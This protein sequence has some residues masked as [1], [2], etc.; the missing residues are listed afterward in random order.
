MV[1]V[2]VLVV[3]LSASAGDIDSVVQRSNSEKVRMNSFHFR[4]ESESCEDETPGRPLVLDSVKEFW[5]SGNSFRQRLRTFYAINSLGEYVRSEGEVTE[6][7]YGGSE[8][9]TL[10]G[11]DPDHPLRLPLEFGRNA[12]EFGK[13]NG[14]LG[15]I[16]GWVE[17]R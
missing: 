12:A 15:V 2:V 14:G 16:V 6:T 4:V 11:W 5:A 8:V 10:R 1:G 7:S 9:R 17:R 3:V 13:I